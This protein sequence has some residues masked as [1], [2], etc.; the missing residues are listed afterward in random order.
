[1]HFTEAFFS[2]LTDSAFQRILSLLVVTTVQR[3]IDLIY[4]HSEACL[5]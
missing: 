1:M 3:H 5:S 2:W 4:L